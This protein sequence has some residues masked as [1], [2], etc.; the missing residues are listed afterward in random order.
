MKI[1]FVLTIA[2]V[3]CFLAAGVQAQNEKTALDSYLETGKTIVIARC[4]SRSP[5][6]HTSEYDATVEILHVVKGAEKNREI[7]VVLKF[8]SIEEGKTYLLRT[9]NEADSKY[10]PY[11]FVKGYDSAIPISSPDEVEKLKTLPLR[12]VVL[13]TMN[14]RKDYLDS[15]IRRRSYELNALEQ[16]TKGQ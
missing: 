4:V 3:A 8:A 15:E 2:L 1:K 13:R 10:Q 11:F 9:E 5:V 12:I 7:T 14:I 6:N 16:I